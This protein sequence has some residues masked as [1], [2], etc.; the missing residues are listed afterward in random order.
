MNR[1]PRPI[2]VRAFSGFG[3]DLGLA[4]LPWPNVAVDDV[5]QLDD[6]QVVRVTDVVDVPDRS[7]V[8]ALVKVRRLLSD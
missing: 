7:A 8:H 4:E 6:G 5:I 3:D 1:A 2:V